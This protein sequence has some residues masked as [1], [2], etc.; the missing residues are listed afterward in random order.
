MKYICTEDDDSIMFDRY[1]NYI[2]PLKEGIPEEFRD[3]A[4]ESRF[5]DPA[6]SE[7]LHD[8]RPSKVNISE[9][10]GNQVT[11]EPSCVSIFMEFRGARRMIFLEYSGVTNYCMKGPDSP[12]YFDTYHGDLFTHEFRIEKEGEFI[13]EIAFVTGASMIIA[14]K[15]L[16]HWSEEY[17]E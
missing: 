10:V 13:H 8:A 12:T 16:R 14:F 9:T 2:L 7:S 4:T 17:P 3:L 1:L 5:Y 11:N 6:S 15:S